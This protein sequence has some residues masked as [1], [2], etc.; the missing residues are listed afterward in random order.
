M[1]LKHIRGKF[2]SKTEVSQLFETVNN[3]KSLEFDDKDK[4]I[5]LQK[6]FRSFLLSVSK[7][8][9]RETRNPQQSV[10]QSHKR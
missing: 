1:F 6:Q 3:V 5:I 9:R 2:K 8:V 4:A 7:M 10:D